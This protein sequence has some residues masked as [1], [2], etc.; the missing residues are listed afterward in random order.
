M[1]HFNFSFVLKVCGNSTEVCNI[2]GA[3]SDCDVDSCGSD[4]ECKIG[5]IGKRCENCTEGYEAIMGKPGVVREDGEGV[6]CQGRF[7]FLIISK[8][9]TKNLNFR[10]GRK[11]YAEECQIQR[12]GV[13]SF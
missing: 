6:V 11:L 9:Q 3:K 7:F 13:H 1:P 4:G 5:Y 8:S 10:N 2:H 12:L